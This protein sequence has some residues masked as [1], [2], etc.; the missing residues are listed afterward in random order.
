MNSS[1]LILL[2]FIVIGFTYEIYAQESPVVGLAIEKHAGDITAYDYSPDG[3]LL[4]TVSYDRCL[5][6]WDSSTLSLKATVNVPE[7]MSGGILNLCRFH[8]FN[9]DVVFVSGNTSTL[10]Q[11]E[12]SEDGKIYFFYALDWK[13]NILLDKFGFFSDEVA[14]VSVSPNKSY[15]LVASFYEKLI[16]YDSISMAVIDNLK[17]DDEYIYSCQFIDDSTFVV[18]SDLHV[19]KYHIDNLGNVKR[20]GRLRTNFGDGSSRDYYLNKNQLLIEYFGYSTLYNISNPLLCIADLEKMKWIKKKVVNKKEDVV[21]AMRDSLLKYE[22]CKLKLDSIALSNLTYRKQPAPKILLQDNAI[23]IRYG[24]EQCWQMTFNGLGAS[25]LPK[26]NDKD[27]APK[28]IKR[29]QENYGH[30]VSMGKGVYV[31]NICIFAFKDH[32]YKRSTRGTYYEKRLPAPVE[33]MIKCPNVNYVAM[34][35]K[36]GTVRFYNTESGAEELALFIDKTGNWVFW[37][38]TG[39][40]YSDNVRNGR[41]IE[42][43]YQQFSQITIV[44]PL[45]R[46]ERFF[47]QSMINKALT[48]IFTP[49]YEMK[50][51]VNNILL[52][53]FREDVPKISVNGIMKLGDDLIIKYSV[54]D[55]DVF[56]YGSYYISLEIDGK[57]YY[58]FTRIT[59]LN[60]REIR[61]HGIPD[62]EEIMLVLNC[63][64]KPMD[65]IF[66]NRNAENHNIT[67]LALIT[68]GVEE[69]IGK[70]DLNG[71]ISDAM[72][73]SELV[74]SGRLFGVQPLNV[75]IKT[76]FNEQVS[77]DLISEC[78]SDISVRLD[79]S[80]LTIFYYSGHG[81]S[82]NGNYYLL[83]G[84]SKTNEN[85]MN[86]N[87]IHEDLSKIPGDKLIVIDACYSGLAYAEEYDYSYLLSSEFDQVSVAGNDISGS[88]F[89]RKLKELILNSNDTNTSM[90]LAE[91]SERVKSGVYQESSGMQVPVVVINT[92]MSD[93][94]ITQ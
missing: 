15:I 42:W 62:Y 61:V 52:N 63:N 81:V 25:S 68:C 71:T 76:L 60:G 92:K 51:S 46:R 3:S 54:S 9:N 5:K 64:S 23:Y 19:E 40:Y 12:R 72:D 32:L 74:S 94:Q 67:H 66:H 91:L 56:T 55:Y 93:L 70:P 39:F 16:L 48:A 8:P 80:S 33:Q 37:T 77:E 57:P 27:S 11:D 73:M 85:L 79:D 69:F 87:D 65:Y 22:R 26:V 7:S 82:Y 41:M 17:L 21:N 49:D 4:A 2:C 83:S 53:E 24:S 59:N 34:S 14:D 88:L 47:S 44:K 86:I 28:V 45:E 43:R 29:I 89:T 31:G 36:D 20:V 58:D 1:R 35:L 10:M 84:I 75:I 18:R 38:P 13:R 90:S 78:I 50:T 6:I 30:H